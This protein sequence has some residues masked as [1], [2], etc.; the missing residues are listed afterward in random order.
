MRNKTHTGGWLALALAS[1]QAS[2]LTDVPVAFDVD[3]I[4]ARGMAGGLYLNRVRSTL[5]LAVLYQ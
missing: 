5:L 3:V 1:V 2:L 4:R